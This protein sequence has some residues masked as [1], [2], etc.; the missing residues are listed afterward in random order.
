MSNSH[1]GQWVDADALVVAWLTQQCPTAAVATVVPATIPAGGVIWVATVGGP[2]NFDQAKIRI[3]LQV[4][5][6]GEFGAASSLAQAAHNAMGKLGGQLVYY[7]GTSQAV[8]ATHCVSVPSRH[9]WAD[10]VDR[11][12]GTYQLDLPVF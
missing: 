6:P 2:S 5:V 4:I 9:K 10:H 12:I 11:L 1:V 8:H 3:D 7:G